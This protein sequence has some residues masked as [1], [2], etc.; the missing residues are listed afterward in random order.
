ME[1]KEAMTHLLHVLEKYPVTEEEKQAIQTAI[2][3]LSWTS[4]R[5]GAVKNFVENR[6]VKRKRNIR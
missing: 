4:L 1:D 5:K 6:E 2:G 3:I